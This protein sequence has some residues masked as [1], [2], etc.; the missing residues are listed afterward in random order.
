MKTSSE[1]ILTTHVGSLPRPEALLA[2][3]E[4][5]DQGREYD[6]GELRSEK[7]RAVADI[8]KRQVENGIDIVSDGEMGKLSYTIYAKHRLNGVED[9][10]PLLFE[11]GGPRDLQEHPG[12]LKWR[13]SL[14]DMPTTRY[15]PPRTTSTVA[16]GDTGPVETDI[17]DFAAATADTLPDEAFLNTASPGVLPAFVPDAFYGNEDAYVADL[18][19]AMKVEYDAIHAAGFLVQIDCPDLAM[20]RH[21]A[22][23]DKNDGEFLKIA[24]RN[25]EALNHACRDIP[26]DRLRMHVCWGNYPG[27]HTHDIAISKIVDVVMKAKPQA[28]LFE[29]ANSRHAHEHED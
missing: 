17:A 18:A 2:L 21:I 3:L 12:Y 28:V 11:H 15:T 16:Y 13:E 4:A 1:R 27:P 19:D 25:V 14:R 23:Q 9:G 22:H 24:E 5:Q 6:P 20:N 7:R 10:G 29:A 26:A 8:V